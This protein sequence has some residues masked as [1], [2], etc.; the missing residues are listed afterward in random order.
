MMIHH[1]SFIVDTT[2]L[3]KGREMTVNSEYYRDYTREDD[4]HICFSIRDN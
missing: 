1:S 2:Y 3:D 4:L